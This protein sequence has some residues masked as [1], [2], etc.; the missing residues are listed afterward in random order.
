MLEGSQLP[1]KKKLRQLPEPEMNVPFWGN[2]LRN[3]RF[4]NTNINIVITRK[5]QGYIRQGEFEPQLG[6]HSFRYFI[7][8]IV[9][10]VIR[11]SPMG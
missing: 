1:T 3:E 2:F 10:S 5:I 9:T 11:L 8:V 6:Q 7:K 4:K